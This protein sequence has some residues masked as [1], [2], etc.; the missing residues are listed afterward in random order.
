MM[1]GIKRFLDR[2]GRRFG[3]TGRL[4]LIALIAIAIFVLGWK[5]G[6][7]YVTNIY[8]ELIGVIL[9]TGVTVVIVDQFYERRDRELRKE[10][11]RR[12]KESRTQAL[13][14][15]LLGEVD[16]EVNQI[17]LRAIDTIASIRLVDR[18][19]QPA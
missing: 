17:A 18:Q 10:Q 5:G 11:Q 2:R 4:V 8:T 6:E 15:R 13:K 12:D 3:W 19:G 1:N 9:S 14:E 7:D 16:S